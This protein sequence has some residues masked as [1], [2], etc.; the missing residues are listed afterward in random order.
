MRGVFIHISNRSH[1]SLNY[2]TN[3]HHSSKPTTLTTLAPLEAKLKGGFVT[4]VVVIW[5]EAV[6]EFI[7]K[8]RSWK[9][10]KHMHV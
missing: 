9:Q 6:K 10:R 5:Y 8:G 4:P 2:H 7:S 3:S 1:H